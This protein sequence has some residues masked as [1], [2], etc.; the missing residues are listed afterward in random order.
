MNKCINFAAVNEVALGALP[1]ILSRWLPDGKRLGREFV[2]RN[3]T[4]ADRAA[5]SFRINVVTGKWADFATNDRGSGVI[6]LAA[7][8]FRLSQPEAARFVAGM[9]GIREGQK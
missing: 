2:A 4:R 6:S 5:G 8:L 1:L 7:Y 3:P 9:L